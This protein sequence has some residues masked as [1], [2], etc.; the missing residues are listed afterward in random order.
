MLSWLGGGMCYVDLVI[1]AWGPVKR[2]RKGSLKVIRETA[3][4]SASLSKQRSSL[5][6]RAGSHILLPCDHLV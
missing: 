4:W 5:R 3:R 2:E 6:K 1:A